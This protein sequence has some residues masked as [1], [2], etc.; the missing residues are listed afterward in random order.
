M[1]TDNTRS[2]GPKPVFCK[3]S[4][5]A[6]GLRWWSCHDHPQEV[7]SLGKLT[8][9]V[10]VAALCG[11][12]NHSVQNA[13]VTKPRISVSLPE[14]EYRELSALAEKH[15]ISLAWLGRQAIL[16][17]LERHQDRE[18]QLPLTMPSTGPTKR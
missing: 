3:G 5:F 14:R 7:D 9:S 17:F 13:M 10:P 15:R 8:H 6:S 2:V 12:L 11:E 1:N 4:A 16:E 18:L